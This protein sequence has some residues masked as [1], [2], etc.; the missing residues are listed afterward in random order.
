MAAKANTVTADRAL[1]FLSAGKKA[2]RV[3]LWSHGAIDRAATAIK[4]C[5]DG[6]AWTTFHFNEQSAALYQRPPKRFHGFEPDLLP[7]FAMVE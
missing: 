6:D 1:F 3:L 7:G 4:S 5:L 2:L